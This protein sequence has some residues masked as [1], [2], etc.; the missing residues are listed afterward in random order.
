MNK[1]FRQ[2][3]AM[4][5]ATN[6][7]FRGGTTTSVAHANTREAAL[8]AGITAMARSFGVHLKPIHRIDARGE[9]SIVALDK[10]K[11]SNIG[12]GKFGQKFTEWLN[13]AKPRTGIVPCNLSS[14]AGWCYINHFEVEKMVLRYSETQT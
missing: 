11:P 3:I 7:D 10:D 1:E 2:A 4:L 9:L 12:C 8:I 5:N 13:T 14:D 6:E